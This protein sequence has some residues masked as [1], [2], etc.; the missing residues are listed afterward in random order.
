MGVG[1]SID[2]GPS[3]WQ[4]GEACKVTVYLT[5]YVFMCVPFY[6]KLMAGL[7]EGHPVVDSGM[8]IS[9]CRYLLSCVG[10]YNGVMRKISSVWTPND[11]L[12]DNCFLCIHMTGLYISMQDC[13]DC[14]SNAYQALFVHVV[15]SRLTQGI[16]MCVS[17]LL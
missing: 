4:L 13:L 14:L 16:M 8:R 3:R 11:L 7:M 9:I 6:S 5:R 10:V 1:L 2:S 15:D 12:Y 17:I